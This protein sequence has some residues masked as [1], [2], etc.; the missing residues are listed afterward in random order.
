MFK[1]MHPIF[2]V[3]IALLYGYNIGIM[4]LEMTVI[5][6][7]DGVGIAP[8]FIYTSIISLCV[9]NMA[10]AL[11]WVYIPEKA[12]EREKQKNEEEEEEVSSN[13]S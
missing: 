9:I 2:F 10:L 1:G 6:P 4:I 7:Y 3:G 5:P 12:E 8:Q 11:M 13:G